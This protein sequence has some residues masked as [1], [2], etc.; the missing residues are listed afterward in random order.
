MLHKKKLLLISS[1]ESLP[2]NKSILAASAQKFRSIKLARMD[3]LKI[4]KQ[5]TILLLLFVTAKSI[6]QEFRGG[7]LWFDHVGS[8]KYDIYVDVY[9]KD[10]PTDIKPYLPICISCI[11]PN[12]ID[13][14][15]LILNESLN[16]DISLLRYKKTGYVFDDEDKTYTIN[17]LDSFLLPPLK[18]LAGPK[19]DF[20]YLTGRVTSLSSQFFGLNDPPVFPNHPIEYWFDDGIFYLDSKA[21]DADGD[22]LFYGLK[23]YNYPFYYDY[24]YP[25]ATDTVF[26]GFTNGLIKWDKPTEPG[27][28]LL[29]VD[30]AEYLTSGYFLSWGTRDMIIEIKA[31]D[32]TSQREILMEKMDFFL[33]P[34]PATSTVRFQSKSDVPVQVSIYS[35]AGVEAMPPIE[36]GPL[37]SVEMDVS[38]LPKGAYWARAVSAG[39]VTSQVLIIQ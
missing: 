13:T 2:C 6:S 25:A 37:Q 7:Q 26:C 11:P 27:K 30:F 31:E 21:L 22:T 3:S 4:M 29:G 15:H 33:S 35:A 20:L 39:G 10:I 1:K 28:Y 24:S 36:V 16:A 17:V 8:N 5:F 23:D 9:F 38:Q 34:N 19:K 12:Y 18:N 14:A 32:I